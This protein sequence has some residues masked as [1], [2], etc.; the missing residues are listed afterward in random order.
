MH[1][2]SKFCTYTLKSFS[3]YL[4]FSGLTQ[5]I[6]IMLKTVSVCGLLTP[7]YSLS[8]AHL[9]KIKKGLERGLYSVKHHVSSTKTDKTF[10]L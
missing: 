7:E 10:S 4:Q 2:F 9:H 6:F 3:G 5:I 1:L 8:S